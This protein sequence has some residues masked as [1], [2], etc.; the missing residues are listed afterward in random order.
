MPAACWVSVLSRSAADGRPEL[1]CL[2]ALENLAYPVPIFTKHK[3]V[4]ENPFWHSFCGMRVA[5]PTGEKDFQT[6]DVSRSL[7]LRVHSFYCVGP[8]KAWTHLS[9]K[10]VL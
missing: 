3:N 8:L 9:R 5:V 7:S 2:V 4:E 6:R 10:A 1:H